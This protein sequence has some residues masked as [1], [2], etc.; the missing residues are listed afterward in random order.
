MQHSFIFLRQAILSWC[1]ISSLHIMLM[2]FLEEQH[3]SLQS[4]QTN[5]LC[6]PS[7]C[8]HPQQTGSCDF[9]ETRIDEQHRRPLPQP[10]HFHMNTF[11]ANFDSQDVLH[12]SFTFFPHVTLKQAT[13]SAVLNIVRPQLLLHNAKSEQ[14]FTCVRRFS[15]IIYGDS[16]PYVPYFCWVTRILSS[17]LLVWSVILPEIQRF[18][19]NFVQNPGTWVEVWLV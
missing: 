11:P 14:S 18:H 10:T 2:K 15:N 16:D 8:R 4:H 5:P 9:D 19:R 13:F 1:Q 6:S 12:F 3:N 7:V 17:I